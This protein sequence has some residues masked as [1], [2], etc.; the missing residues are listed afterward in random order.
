MR[1]AARTASCRGGRSWSPL[2]LRALLFAALA[3]AG[4]VVVASPV[5]A[6]IVLAVAV[7]GPNAEGAAKEAGGLIAGARAAVARI[8]SAGGLRGESVRVTAVEDGCT[9]DGAIAAARSIIAAQP[10]AV[11][12][13]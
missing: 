12:T 11:L 10:A 9:A 7:P 13:R 8:N 6:E 1:R 5:R 2:C 3:V 4:G